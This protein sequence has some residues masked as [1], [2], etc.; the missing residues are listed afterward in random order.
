MASQHLQDHLSSVGN[1]LR[2]WRI[3]VN[4]AK[5]MHV[6]FTNRSGQCPPIY[7]DQQQIPQGTSVKYLGMHLDSK[8]TWREHIINKRKQLDHK[9]RKLLWIIGRTSPLSLENKLLIYKTVLK[10]VW[11][12]GIEL[13]GCASKTNVA[14]IQRYQSKI[15]RIITNAPWYVSNQTLHSDLRIQSAQSVRDE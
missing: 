1:W 11:T 14:I 15:L 6:T 2:K 13:W 8:L 5:S 7:I 9:T 10:P 4:Q 12:Y 3:K